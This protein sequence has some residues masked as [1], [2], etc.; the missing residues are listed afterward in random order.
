M[1]KRV[2][3]PRLSEYIK[4]GLSINQIAQIY[5]CSWDTVRIRV[6]E[7]AELYEVKNERN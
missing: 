5:G 3:M 1:K 4:Q 2:D 7:N 6:Y